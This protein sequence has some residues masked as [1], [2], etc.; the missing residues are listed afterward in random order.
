MCV[1]VEDE[2]AKTGMIPEGP[3]VELEGVGKECQKEQ[4]VRKGQHRQQPIRPGTHPTEK[5]ET[6]N[7]ENYVDI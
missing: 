5:W 6:E 2:E 3:M 1:G 7:G 4:T